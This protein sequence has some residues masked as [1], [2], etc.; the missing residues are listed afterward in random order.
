MRFFDFIEQH[1]RVGPA[2]NLL[3][4]LA[5]F[6]VADVSGRGANQAGDGVFLHVLGHVNADQGM[7]IIKKEFR[8]SAGK[9]GFADAG[10][11]EKDEGADGALGIAETGTGAADGAGD[12][13]E[14]RILADDSLAQTVFHG[15]QL[16]DF[17]FKHF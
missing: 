3:G 2:S 13:L 7:L 14:R 12:A 4:E 1:N 9:F 8:Q 5:A 16:F 10:G 11:T 6:F 15:D 17:A